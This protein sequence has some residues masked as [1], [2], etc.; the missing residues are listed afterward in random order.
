[1]VIITVVTNTESRSTRTRDNPVKNDTQSLGATILVLPAKIHP[2]PLVFISSQTG[3]GSERIAGRRGEG[4]AGDPA[5]RRGDLPGLAGDTNTGCTP[6]T[7][8]I[9]HPRPQ[10]LTNTSNA[11]NFLQRR[12]RYPCKKNPLI[13][14]LVPHFC[15][16]RQIWKLSR[17]SR[18][19]HRNC[20]KSSPYITSRWFSTVWSCLSFLE[21][22]MTEMFMRFSKLLGNR[23]KTN[24]FFWGKSFFLKFSQAFG[25]VWNWKNQETHLSWSK[26]SLILQLGVW[27]NTN[28]KSRTDTTLFSHYLL[29][30]HHNSKIPSDRQWFLCTC[31]SRKSED[32]KYIN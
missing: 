10:L 9:L 23:K 15:N 24:S 25:W 2:S 13:N 31:W 3:S 12:N 5:V 21:A 22:M 4:R 32:L 1:M 18:F 7:T 14:D 11:P 16:T 19:I 17:K 26:F 27:K 29:A 8:A 28:C 20:K 6:T 30:H